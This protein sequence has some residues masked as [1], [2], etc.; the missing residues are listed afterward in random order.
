MTIKPK[1]KNL[2]RSSNN[3]IKIRDTIQVNREGGMHGGLCIDDTAHLPPVKQAHTSAMVLAIRG[4]PKCLEH[5]QHQISF[6][7]Q[8]PWCYYE[9]PLCINDGA[10]LLS[11]KN[12]N[13]KS[14]FLEVKVRPTILSIN[15]NRSHF[16]NR[17]SGIILNSHF[18]LFHIDTLTLMQVRTTSNMFSYRLR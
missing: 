8:T 4:T 11:V 2:K 13:R 9:L 15:N 6:L 5:Q 16:Q 10:R 3:I 1:R 12:E 17:L 14:W 7:E 18:C